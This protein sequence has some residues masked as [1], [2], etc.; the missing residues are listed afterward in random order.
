MMTYEI[1]TP[2]V[3]YTVDANRATFEKGGLLGGS[4]VMRL[5]VRE[6]VSGHR[7]HRQVAEIR[8]P[9]LGWVARPIDSEECEGEGDE[10]EGEAE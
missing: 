1:V 7:R 6:T 3:T 10:K 4:D 8:E 9:I 5:F 2:R